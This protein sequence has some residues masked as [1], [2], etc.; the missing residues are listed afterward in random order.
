MASL[1]IV[2]KYYGVC[3]VP[4]LAAHGLIFN[5]RPGRWMLLLLIP[6]ATACLYQLA[7]SSLYGSGLFGAAA[8]YASFAKEHYGFSKISAGLIGLTFTGGCVA[9]AVF[10]AP[11]VWKRTPAI[12]AV[13]GILAIVFFFLTRTVL[14]KYPT[15]EPGSRTLVEIQMVF[16]ALGGVSVL[17]LAIAEVRRRPD[18]QSWLL[19]LWVWG[20]FLFAALVNWTVNGRSILPMAPAVAILVVRRMELRES[21]RLGMQTVC[22]AVGAI[23]ALLVVS[24][25]VSHAN[26][27][28]NV[29]DQVS[30]KYSQAPGK[31]WFQGHWGFQYYMQ[32]L[33]WSP[34][35]FKSSPLA[36]GDIVAVPSNNTNLLPPTPEKSKLLDT[37][38]AE[39]FA[40]A[41][42]MDQ[43]TGAGF[44]SS[45]WGPLPFAI[46]RAASE[47]VTVYELKSPAVATPENPK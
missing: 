42:T 15:I 24:A 31:H 12:F 11:L 5:R 20:T 7:T 43:G 36:P 22:L 21:V 10:F 27:V 40:V 37:F 34:V 3:L 46:G 25:D 39:R 32:E 2:T 4:L 13:V 28:W 38:T 26:A 30:T 29:S 14:Q 47:Q 9:T 35:D 17:A 1:A 44:Y 6:L 33:G 45:V 19:G 16:W 41:A 8:H 23:V 18:A